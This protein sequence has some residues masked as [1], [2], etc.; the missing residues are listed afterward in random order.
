MI[1]C[2][3]VH[4]SA[5]L[6]PVMVFGVISPN[7][8]TSF[9]VWITCSRVIVRVRVSTCFRT[10]LTRQMMPFPG[11]VSSFSQSLML[12]SGASGPTV[13]VA[14]LFRSSRFSGMLSTRNRAFA[15]RLCPFSRI[16]QT[17]PCSS[18]SSGTRAAR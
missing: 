13:M 9:S 12:I 8:A 15:F 11:S 7:I 17:A 6:F 1:A 4:F 14:W 10:V 3:A 16:I 5:L 2:R 18:P